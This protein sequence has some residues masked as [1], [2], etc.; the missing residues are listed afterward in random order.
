MSN[1]IFKSFNLGNNLIDDLFFLFENHRFSKYK[2]VKSSLH[3][4]S[5]PQIVL[6]NEKSDKDFIVFPD[7][8]D[9]L[10]NREIL[11]RDEKIKPKINK[12]IG[13]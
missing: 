4:Y 10:R 1:L 2:K 13:F 8:I 6:S 11:F 5:W 12:I 3:L 9:D 7:E